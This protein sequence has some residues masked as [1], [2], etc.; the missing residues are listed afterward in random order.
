MIATAVVVTEETELVDVFATALME[1]VSAT[2][3]VCAGVAES[4][5]AKLMEVL[6]VA[7]VG[8]PETTPVLADKDSPAGS[9]PLATDQ[10]YGAL[11][12]LAASV[13]VYA[14]PTCPAG[15]V[16]VVMAM[17]CGCTAETDPRA[18]PPSLPLPPPQPVTMNVMTITKTKENGQL[19]DLGAGFDTDTVEP[20]GNL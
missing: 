1:S 4:A 15:S 14:T 3:L 8:V 16:V 7:A 12:P 5:T 11:P 17:D 10:V 19:T 2:V 13:V 9:V 18:L 20:N 6:V